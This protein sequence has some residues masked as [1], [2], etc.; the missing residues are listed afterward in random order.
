MNNIPQPLVTIYFIFLAKYLKLHHFFIPIINKQKNDPKVFVIGYW[1]TCTTSV[2]DGLKIL[3]Y[4]SGRLVKYV[5]KKKESW[6]EFVRRSNYDAFTDDPMHEI[7]EELDKEFPNSKFI[8][9]EREIKKFIKSYRNYFEGSEFQRTPEQLVDIYN[10]HVNSV[11][12]FFKGR[13]DQLLV[14]RVADG[15][16]WEKLCKFLKKPIPDIPFPHSN[17]GRYKKKK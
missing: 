7:Y 17:K 13:P 6:P 2:F 14:M 5:K 10:D 3:G 15:D 1:K 9:T 11:K 4:R 8:L 16:G 12:K